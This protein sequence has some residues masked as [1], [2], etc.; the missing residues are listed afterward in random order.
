[1]TEMG[2]KTESNRERK[3]TMVNAI[4]AGKVL[5]MMAMIE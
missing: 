1:M 3:Q 2:M 5:I 4:V